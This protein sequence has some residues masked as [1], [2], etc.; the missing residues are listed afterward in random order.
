[1]KV[2]VDLETGR[3]NFLADDALIADFVPVAVNHAV[4]R[5][6]V[7]GPAGLRLDDLWGV[8]YTKTYDPKGDDHTRDVPFTIHTFLDE[9]FQ[10]RPDPVD[11]ASPGYDD[12]DW[13]P[14]PVWPYAHGGERHAGE[15]LYLRTRIKVEQ[16][17]RAELAGQCL[18]PSGEIW[19]NGRPV[20]VRHDRHP[21]AIDVTPYLNPGAENLV[22][23]R[24]DP[25]KVTRTMRH[26]PAD[27]NTGWFAGRMNLD[28]TAR[29]WIKDVFVYTESLSGGVAV[30]KVRAVIR[31]D[32]I[33]FPA[34]REPKRENAFKGR[35]S[36][37]LFSE[38]T[39][40]GRGCRAMP[41]HNC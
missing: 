14:V 32:H 26:T 7:R 20:E 41:L 6:A 8:G 28:L 2:E 38:T 9:H 19:I 10:V 18:D 23:V 40:Y 36:V 30:M 12:T 39:A 25:F 24:I 5:L 4:G 1:L 29:R 13:Q 27:L 22:A 11:W 33:L 16:F 21:F 37:S 17:E 31:N 3:Y 34:E 35:V 15:T